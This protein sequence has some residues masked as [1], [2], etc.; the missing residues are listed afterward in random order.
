MPAPTYEQIVDAIE[1]VMNTVSGLGKVHDYER[2][3]ER[4]SDFRTLYE[5][6]N[7]GSKEVRGWFIRRV[8]R[9]ERSE[10]NGRYAVVSTWRIQGYRSF[11]DA[12]ASEKLF[13]A[14][15]ENLCTAFRNDETLGG[16]V[17]S[18]IVGEDAGLQVIDSGPALFAGVLCHA[19]NCRLTTRHYL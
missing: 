2:Y 18:T 10:Y 17:D 5:F 1:A 9:R 11:V 13:N 19:A 7:A 15:L 8:T 12:Q 16:V 14:Q 6:D 3:A 4:T